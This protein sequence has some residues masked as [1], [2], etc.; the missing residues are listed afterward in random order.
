[1]N[2]TGTIRATDDANPATPETGTLGR[3]RTVKMLMIVAF[4]LLSVGSSLNATRIHSPFE[5]TGCV[6]ERGTK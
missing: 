2:R 4:A 6:K 3:S 5:K 1:M